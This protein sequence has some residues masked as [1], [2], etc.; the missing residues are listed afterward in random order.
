MEK[1]QKVVFDISLK[2]ILKIL[3]VLA[4]LWLAYALRDV[5]VLLVVVFI[6]V[7]ALEPFVHK[8]SEQ[9]IPRALSIIVLY[10]AIISLLSIILYFLIPPIA[11][12][13]KELTFNFPYYQDKIS[14]I[15]LGGATSTISK[16]LDDLSSKLSSVTGNIITGIV[17]VFGGVVSTV[18]VLVLTYYFLV[19]KQGVAKMTLK[20]I[21]KNQQGKFVETI[22][23]VSVK[24]SDWIQ[25]QLVLMLVVGV[26]DWIALSII[27]IPY[28]L[29]LGVLSGLLEI[30]PVIGP[31]VAAVFAVFIALV[32]SAALWKIIAVVVVYIIVQQL[33]NHILVPKIM[34][35]AVGLSPI[36][37]IIA[38][39]IGSK[40]LGVGGAL[41]A[42]PIA[43]GL[44]VLIEEYSVGRKQSQPS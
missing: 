3:A 10:L 21:P 20:L 17:S 24:L 6:I 12:Q 22:N 33:E 39:L 7:I 5:I 44:Q 35:K 11:N 15:D 13:L 16:I 29:V 1:I 32:A 27:G 38:I 42:V 19:D 43:A 9:G 36:V 18:T 30:V 28:A 23:K 37:V 31:V 41:L 2:S 25:G 40:L 14:Q 34:Q 8:L 26:V 4:G